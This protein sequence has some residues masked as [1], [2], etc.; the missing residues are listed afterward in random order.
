LAFLE[1]EGWT[2][3]WDKSLNVLARF[4]LQLLEDLLRRQPLALGVPAFTSRPAHGINHV[5]GRSIL[6]C[7]M[8]LM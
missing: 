7:P 2:A 8:T 3:W 1:A 6:R 4:L 5:D